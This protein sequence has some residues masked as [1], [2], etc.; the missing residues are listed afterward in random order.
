[1]AYLNHFD[2]RLFVFNLNI[3]IE[4]SLL[5]VFWGFDATAHKIEVRMKF[6]EVWKQNKK[7]GHIFI[8]KDTDTTKIFLPSKDADTTKI[9][10]P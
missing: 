2:H 3:I 6:K 7:H 4:W 9:F 10:L 5:N 8:D 1:M